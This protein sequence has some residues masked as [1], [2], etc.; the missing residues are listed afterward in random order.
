M[1]RFKSEGVV[2]REFE[3]MTLIFWDNNSIYMYPKAY[4]IGTIFHKWGAPR[5]FS[6]EHWG[7][8]R[9]R[10]MYNKNLTLSK[11]YELALTHEIVATS[12]VRKLDLEGRKVIVRK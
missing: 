5:G 1:G 9:R 8:F 2:V 12:T 6:G 11:C 4:R 7:D 10:L 3:E